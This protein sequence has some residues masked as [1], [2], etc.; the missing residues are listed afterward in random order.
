MEVSGMEVKKERVLIVEDNKGIR[1]LLA[2]E[3]K[4]HG[5]DVIVAGDGIEAMS[6]LKEGSPDILLLDLHLPHINGLEVLTRLRQ[7][8]WM[9]VIA[10][11]SHTEMGQKALQLGADRFIAKPFDPEKLVK[12]IKEILKTEG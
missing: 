9:P 7:D 12:A 6:Q 1:K 10:I 5:Y 8:S 2:L 11:S 4:L 3:L